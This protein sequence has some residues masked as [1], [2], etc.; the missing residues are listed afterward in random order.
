MA[1]SLNMGYLWDA[2]P[3]QGTND[4][5]SEPVYAGILNSRV[6]Q[7]FEERGYRIVVFDSGAN[8]LN[9]RDVDQF[10]TPLPKP[11]FSTQIDPF[12]YIFLDTTALHPLMTR[13]FFLQNKYVYNYNLILFALDQLPQ[14]ARAE[15]PKFVYVHLLIPTGR[16][17]LCRMVR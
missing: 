5:N 7:E 8:W 2:L 15:G 12:E 1:S 11:L 17:Y 9:W 3:N 10:V 4:R 6:R 16:I 13:P 14:V